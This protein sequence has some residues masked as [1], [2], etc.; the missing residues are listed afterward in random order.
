MPGCASLRVGSK[1][2]SQ[3]QRSVSSMC[4]R[5]RARFGKYGCQPTPIGAGCGARLVTASRTSSD[6]AVSEKLC[7]AL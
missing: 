3:S 2:A 7:R 5:L 4:R 6:P 1:V